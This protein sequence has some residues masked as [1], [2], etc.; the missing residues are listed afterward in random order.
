M[1]L[2]RFVGVI[3]IGIAAVIAVALLLPARELTAS[4]AHKGAEPE[5]FALALAEAR[6]MAHPDDGGAIDEL[7]R[8]LGAAG[9]KDWAL[10][11]AIRGSEHAEPS[12]TRWRALLAA[13]VAYVDRLEVVPALDYANR[14][15]TACEGQQAACPSWEEVR[16]KL[17]QQH[18]SAGVASGIDPRRGPESARAF[19]RAGER[20]LRQIRL[21]GERGGTPSDGARG[22]ANGPSDG[23]R[24]SANGPP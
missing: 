7:S 13:S 24:G 19:R 16:M 18:L 5:R 21:G 10:E 8:R 3:D 9:F 17:Y 15:L 14:A 22:S 11:V 23:A 2:R 6:T 12:A 1:Q 4:A 20:A